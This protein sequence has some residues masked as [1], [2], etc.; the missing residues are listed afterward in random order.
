M[1]TTLQTIRKYAKSPETIDT[2]K[3]LGKRVTFE[4]L[5]SDVQKFILQS[6]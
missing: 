2:G 4:S 5:P 1:K 3:H 6:I